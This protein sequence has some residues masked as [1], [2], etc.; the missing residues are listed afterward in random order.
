MADRLAFWE[1]LYASP[2]FEKW[3]GNFREVLMDEEANAEFSQF[4]ADKI[5][6]R[7]YDP[8]VA[9]QLIPKDHGFGVQRVPLE[10]RYYEA[11]NLPNV[12][13]VN[14]EETPVVEITPSGIRTTDRERAFDVIIYATGFDAITGAF[15]R[16]DVT[17]AGGRTLRDAWAGDPVTYLGVMVHG[18]PNLFMLAG[19]QG[20]SNSTNF[21]RAIE[22]AVD[23]TT[24]LFEHVTAEGFTRIEAS[25]EAQAEWAARIERLYSGLLL[26]KA[27]SWFTGYNSNIDGYD[28]VRHMIYN[29]GLP[30]YRKDLTA[31]VDAGYATLH[32]SKEA[33]MAPR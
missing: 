7:V 19:P 5:R 29:G 21:P 9:E 28:R 14:I 16:M 2:G 33:V 22:V 20:A 32:R 26:R 11:Y 12:H 24:K 30:R 18:F 31:V 25:A 27:R 17:G 15:S 6:A 1:R 8:V 4:V 10:T 23:W 3:V 13:L